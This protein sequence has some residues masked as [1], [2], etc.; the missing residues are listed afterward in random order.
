MFLHPLADVVFVFG[1]EL[2]FDQ[3]GLVGVR[4]F[5]EGGADS[6]LLRRIGAIRKQLASELGYILPAVPAGT[7]LLASFIWRRE[8]EGEKP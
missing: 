8:Q 6:P 3:L 7:I 1:S 4:Q 5:V 2:E